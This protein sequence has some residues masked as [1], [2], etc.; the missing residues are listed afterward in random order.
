MSAHQSR[1]AVVAAGRHEG[2]PLPSL[3]GVLCPHCRK[4]RTTM[5]LPARRE[6]K[7]RTPR[8]FYEVRCRGCRQHFYVEPLS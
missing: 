3:T 5:A 6:T 7:T 2:D 1:L 4:T 8:T